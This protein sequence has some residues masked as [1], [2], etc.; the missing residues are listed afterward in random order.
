[1]PSCPYSHPQAISKEYD[2][3]N[4][5]GKFRDPINYWNHLSSIQKTWIAFKTHFRE[6]HQKLAE[7]GELTLKE[8][9]YGQ[10]N[11]VE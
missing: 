5:T 4:K 11:L 3:I 9:G 10:Q 1:M 2:I 6:A 7:T 8:A